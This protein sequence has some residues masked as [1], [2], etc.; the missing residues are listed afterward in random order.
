MVKVE[1]EFWATATATADRATRRVFW[2]IVISVGA[3]KADDG[4]DEFYEMSGDAA[5]QGPGK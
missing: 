4:Q 1:D 3:R 5:L 2:R